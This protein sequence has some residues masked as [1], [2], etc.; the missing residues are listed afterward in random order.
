MK[1]ST[2]YFYNVRFFEP[3]QVPVSTA[4]WDPK[5]FHDF[6]GEDYIF[7][8]KR[9]VINGVRF[10]M[11]VPDSNCDNLCSG[12]CDN[13]T[14]DN[15]LFLNMY[16]MQ[17]GFLSFDKVIKN[18]K[19]TEANIKHFFG[20]DH[21]I[22]FVFMFHEKPDNRCSERVPVIEWFKNNGMIVKEWERVQE[23]DK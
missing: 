1:I 4:K 7:R 19:I 11:F 9:S 3:W 21:E 14:P 20:I 13:Y 22:E 12:D 16:R 2:S 23:G 18:L 6:Q 8:D 5:W 17:L 15:C 10:L